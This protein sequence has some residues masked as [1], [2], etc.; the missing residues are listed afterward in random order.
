MKEKLFQLFVI[1]FSV[2]YEDALQK[3]FLVFLSVQISK[4]S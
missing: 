1:T 2:V 4:R 3:V